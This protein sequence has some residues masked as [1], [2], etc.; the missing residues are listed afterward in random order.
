[1][2]VLVT[3]GTGFLGAAL[4][5]RLLAAGCRVAIVGPIRGGASRC[6]GR[7]A[8]G[9]SSWSRSRSGGGRTRPAGWPAGR[10]RPLLFTATT[11]FMS[12]EAAAGW[13]RAW[14]TSREFGRVMRG[15]THAFVVDA[16]ARVI[17]AYTLPLNLGPLLSVLLLVALLVAIVQVGKACGKRHLGDV[18]GTDVYVRIVRPAAH[19]PVRT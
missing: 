16:A 19:R 18:L 4:V 15:M 3:G 17:M 2:P 11:R 13:H 8:R 7:S 9:S 10:R 14:G 12:D 5:P 6:G 1:M